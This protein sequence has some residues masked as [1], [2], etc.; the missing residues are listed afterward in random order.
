MAGEVLKT[1]SE[2]LADFPDNS[3][4]L[5]E[6]VNSRNFV[7]SVVTAVGFA[8][9]NPG[10][11][12]VLL[13]MTDGVPVD[14]LA[15]V[16]TPAFAGNFWKLDGNNAFVPSYVDFGIFVPPLTQRLTSGSVIIEVNKPSGGDSVYRFQGTEGGVFTGNPIDRTVTGN[17]PTL[18]VFSGTRLYDVEVGGAI[19]FSITPIGHSLDLEVLDYRVTLEGIL[20]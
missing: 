2:L 18:L 7:A 14:V 9:D 15:A 20:L 1:A 11:L 3:A 13:P 17:T 8:E 10:D 16:P 19:S 6:A 4:G 5:I 12:P